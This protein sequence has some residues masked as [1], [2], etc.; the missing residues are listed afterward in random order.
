MTVG[1]VIRAK[2]KEAGMT[3]ADLAKQLFVSRQLI[4]KWE[5]EKGYP[6]LDQLVA[7]SAFFE[8]SVDY[9]LKGDQKV[10][11]E[12]TLDTKKKRI[13]QGALVLLGIL[14][15]AVSTYLV[16]LTLEG[17]LLQRDDLKIVS[18]EK[19]L[20]PGKSIENRTTKQQVQVPAD[21]TY[22]IK[23][24]TNRPFVNLAHISV[25][26]NRTEAQAIQFIAFGEYGLWDN[27]KEGILTITSLREEDFTGENLNQGKD[28][29][30]LD[31]VKSKLAVQ[32]ALPD[33]IANTSKLLLKGSTLLK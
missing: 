7:L 17:P 18:V 27:Q 19:T 32:E 22:K 33:T 30:L 11:K 20:L 1:K 24:R 9:L 29:Y 26:R 16:L 10:V 8:V 3:Q 12:L 28:I 4:S 14:L 23:V 21:I 5:T 2:R 13:L 6:D 25:Q 15:V 31:R